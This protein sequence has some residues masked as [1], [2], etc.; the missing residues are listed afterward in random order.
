ML[1]KMRA[2]DISRVQ[3][4]RAIPEKGEA[5]VAGGDATPAVRRQTK[6]VATPNV[7]V[8]RCTGII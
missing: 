5:V 8:G 3:V 2:N 7:M 6:L 1:R 4:W